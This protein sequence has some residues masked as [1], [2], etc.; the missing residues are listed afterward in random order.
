MTTP[1]TLHARSNRLPVIATSIR[2]HLEAAEQATRRGLEHAIAAGALLIEAKELV[3]HGEWLPWRQANCRI[4]ERRAQTFMRLAR[5]RH[6][7]ETIKSAAT[8]DLTI[9]AAE[10][11]VGRQDPSARTVYPANS[12]CSA[13]RK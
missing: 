12:T 13:G 3:D 9:A 10:A 1:V 5:H 7:L 6:K 4:S 11:L 8:A 2:D